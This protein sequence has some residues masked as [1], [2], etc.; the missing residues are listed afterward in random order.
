MI[1]VLQT[2]ITSQMWPRDVKRLK[3]WTSAIVPFTSQTRDQKQ[4]IISKVVAD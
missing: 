4:F 3:D 1:P 2:N